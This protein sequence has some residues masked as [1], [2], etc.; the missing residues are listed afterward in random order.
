MVK[1][2]DYE[3]YS[4]SRLMYRAHGMKEFE[5][6]NLTGFETKQANEQRAVH[7]VQA[8]SK[9]RYSDQ[10]NWLLSYS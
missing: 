6:A 2:D 7:V 4:D 9:R 1:R 8:E 3:V 10:P 5:M